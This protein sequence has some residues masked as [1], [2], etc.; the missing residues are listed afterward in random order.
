MIYESTCYDLDL[1]P[2]YSIQ[3]E[4]EMFAESFAND[5]GVLT[6]GAIGD[7][8]RNLWERIKKFFA[9]LWAFITGRKK[10]ADAKSAEVEKK[11]EAKA[12]AVEAKAKA[13]AA[14]A[15]KSNTSKASEFANLYKEASAIKTELA[16]VSQKKFKLPAIDSVD[17]EMN[18]IAGIIEKAMIYSGSQSNHNAL[19]EIDDILERIAKGDTKE[20]SKGEY[21][22]LCNKVLADIESKRD[23]VLNELKALMSKDP[24]D[25]SFNNQVSKACSEFTKAV[26]RIAGIVT[27]ASYKAADAVNSEREALQKKLERIESSLNED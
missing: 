10:E 13:K 14:E 22:K 16:A 26:G 2:S 9:D 3:E 4:C 21:D 23:T 27:S 1:N 12:T 19:D 17:R 8:F 6:E 5:V 15:A 7:F 18:S 11:V 25:A 24:K 20:Y